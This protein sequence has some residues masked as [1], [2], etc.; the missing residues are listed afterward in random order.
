MGEAAASRPER[1]VI[2]IPGLLGSKLT[3][4][5]GETL[6]GDRRSLRNFGRLDLNPT[7]LGPGVKIAG[8]VERIRL[9]GPFWTIHCYDDLLAYLRALGFRDGQTLFPFAYDWRQSN[10]ETAQ[11]FDVFVQEQP[12]L[13]DG[14][15]DVVAHSMGGIVAKV[16]MLEYGG[17]RRVHKAIYLGTPFHGSMNS[18]GTLT[19]GW[20]SFL[21]YIVGGI[22]TIRN[23]ILSFPAVYELFPSYARSCRLGDARAHELLNIYDPEL[24]NARGWLPPAYREGQSRAEAFRSNLRRAELL[25]DLM[26][27][28]IAGVRE[29]KIA[30]DNQSTRL[31]LYVGRTDQSWRSWAFSF[32]RGDGTVPLWSAADASTGNLT[33]VLPSFV[34]H[35][36]IF[37]DEWV[38][39]VLK[40]E[41]IITVPPPVNARVPEI[42]TSSGASQQLELLDARLEPPIVSPGG[43]ARLDVTLRFPAD[44]QIG[45]GDVRGLTAEL[46]ETTAPPVVLVETTDDTGVGEKTLSFAAEL[47]A[48]MDEEVYRIDIYLPPLGRRAAYLSVERA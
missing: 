21:N 41:L 39:E 17:A 3:G 48:P 4:Q 8:L 35:A 25:A 30:G 7:G 23:T 10:Y 34:E 6:W 28:P 27:R 18:L 15:F 14:Q 24:W 12:A 5:G 16:W 1:P 22:D 11:R 37:S 36:T 46:V 33:G 20:G 29:I 31:Y 2:V 19:E 38:K 47:R 43:S 44:A 9:L 42:P 13:R 45:R 32:N 40:R 26:R